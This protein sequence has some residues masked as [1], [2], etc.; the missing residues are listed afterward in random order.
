MER[1]INVSQVSATVLPGVTRIADQR[2]AYIDIVVRLLHKFTLLHVP[3]PFPAHCSGHF[4]VAN[5]LRFLTEND[6]HLS[7]K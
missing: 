6:V 4:R 3:P 2:G 1:G 7:T 5:F